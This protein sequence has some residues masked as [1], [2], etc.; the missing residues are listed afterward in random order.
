MA[1]D[2]A[3][4][5]LEAIDTTG[6]ETSPGTVWFAEFERKG[7]A[8]GTTFRTLKQVMSDPD[9]KPTTAT[10]TGPLVQSIHAHGYPGFFSPICPVTIDTVIQLVAI[11]ESAGA[12]SKITRQ[13][14]TFIDHCTIQIPPALDVN[15]DFIF[16]SETAVASFGSFKANCSI[17]DAE[18]NAILS[19]TGLRP[20]TLPSVTARESLASRHRSLRIVWRPDITRM[21]DVQAAEYIAKTRAAQTAS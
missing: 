13:V 14:P 6:F 20:V 3:I 8:Y 1:D 11:S 9:K 4:S 18:G 7:L 10:A 5:T 2:L 17:G 21:S 15:S 12:V 16:K 19:I